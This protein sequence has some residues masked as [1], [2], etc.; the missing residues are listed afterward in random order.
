MSSSFTSCSIPTT[1][2]PV[3]L[4]RR[5][6]DFFM[7]F[8]HAYMHLH[9]QTRMNNMQ[10]SAVL[11]TPICKIAPIVYPLPTPTISCM[12][13]I[14]ETKVLRIVLQLVREPLCRIC[15]LLKH[16]ARF[17]CSFCFRVVLCMQAPSSFRTSRSRLVPFKPGATRHVVIIY[18]L[19]LLVIVV[20]Y[21]PIKKQTW[22]L[23]HACS[24]VTRPRP[25]SLRSV[26]SAR[27]PRSDHA[28]DCSA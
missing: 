15:I 21:A 6:T 5:R 9:T 25:V 7:S 22:F 11:C 14:R 26:V 4:A 18:I 17:S 2:H 3:R 13:T 10:N 28:S 1:D 20:I 27:P 16:S 19:Y 8:L 23:F 24:C 12:P